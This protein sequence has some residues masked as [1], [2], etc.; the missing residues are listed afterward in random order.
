M[1]PSRLSSKAAPVVGSCIKTSLYSVE[2]LMGSISE[3]EGESKGQGK[4]LQKSD[5]RAIMKGRK[6]SG[7]GW[8]IPD[9][10]QIGT[11]ATQ[12]RCKIERC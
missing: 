9:Q 6:G 2:E 10:P 12:Q 3:K 11:G 8:G 1:R 4:L 7:K 5:G